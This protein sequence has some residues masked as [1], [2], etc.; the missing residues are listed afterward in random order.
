MTIKLRLHVCNMRIISLV[1]F[2]EK[3]TPYTGQTILRKIPIPFFL[4]FL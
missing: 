4:T 1:D 2:A 3:Q